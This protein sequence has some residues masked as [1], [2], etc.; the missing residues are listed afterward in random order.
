MRNRSQWL[1]GILLAALVP[2]GPGALVSA[3]TSAALAAVPDTTAGR[4]F[5]GW[6]EA[7]N[8]DDPDAFEAHMRREYPAWSAPP[9]SSRNLR[10]L[11]G[12]FE[13]VRVESAN[14]SQIVVLLRERNWEDSYARVT[15]DVEPQPGGKITGARVQGAPPPPD[16]GP[17]VR[18]DESQALAAL[19]AKLDAASAAGQFSGAVRVARGGETVFDYVSGQADRAKGV[20]NTLD[21]VF[22]IG[23]MNK[24]FTAVSVLQLAETGKI[25]LDAPIGTYLEDYPN[26]DLASRVTVKHLL[27]HTGGTG[28]IFGPQFMQHRTELCETGDYVALY[29]TREIAFAPGERFAYSNYGYILLGAIV[30]AVSGQDYF[31]YVREHI[32]QPAGMTA[33]DSLPESAD[34]PGRSIGYTLA[35]PTGPLPEPEPN[36]E[37]LP[38]RGSPAGGGYSTVGDLIRFAEALREDKL[39]KP[40]TVQA[41]TT[42]QVAMGPAAGYGYGFGE[43]VVNGARAFG[44][45][46]GAPGMSAELMIFPD[47]GYEVAVAANMDTQL[48]TRFAQFVGARLPVE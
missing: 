10:A 7:F 28:D 2:M 32:Y 39:L 6:L 9:G 37:T 34:V 13:P 23:S 5:T 24:M 29:G 15:I 40:E 27:T 44:H 3:Q 33:S 22:R 35:G 46:G 43:S 16:I 18:M 30:E 26:K 48:V 1:A 36:T 4:Q 11:T 45:N 21:T 20:P 17:I 42:T 47:L 31:A 38:C 19:R 41:A 25:D 8:G 12:G 14:E